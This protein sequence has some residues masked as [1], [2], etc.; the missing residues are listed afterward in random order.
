MKVCRDDFV[1]GLGLELS[2]HGGLG[3]IPGKSKFI[4]LW[5]IKC[6][7]KWFLSECFY[8]LLSSASHRRSVIYFIHLPTMLYTYKFSGLRHH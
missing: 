5:W 3:L 8:S 6:H 4:N 7:L 1:S 2:Y